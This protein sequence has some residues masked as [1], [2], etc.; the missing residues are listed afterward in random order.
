[1]GR[2]IAAALAVAV[3]ASLET[4]DPRTRRRCREVFGTW[5]AWRGDRAASARVRSV[6]EVVSGRAEHA[7]LLAPY[8]RLVRT[9]AGVAPPLWIE[10]PK[11]GSLSMKT[12]MASAFDR[13]EASV[14]AVRANASAAGA[15]FVVVRD[16]WARLKSAF[17]T[18]VDRLESRRGVALVNATAPG[19]LVCALCD[20]VDVLTHAR[21]IAHT[22]RTRLFDEGG[23]TH[24]AFSQ[25]WFLNAWDRPIDNVLR[26]EAYAADVE[27]LRARLPP[28]ALP[29]GAM[30]AADVGRNQNLGGFDRRP[31]DETGALPA[32]CADRVWAHLHQDYEC[33][34]YDVPDALRAAR[35][36]AE[37]DPWRATFSSARRRRVEATDRAKSK[38]TAP[39]PAP[40]GGLA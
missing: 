23:V 1:M 4:V 16:P 7:P 17:G 9:A 6:E 28:D 37:R 12:Y 22:N 38:G 5:D 3:A 11:A 27:A 2:A 13:R 26:L 24:H 25:M 19:D 35:D 34:A 21:D 14:A 8:G 10:V 15:T 30:A 39:A 32:T 18:I 40:P 20:L 36:R 29:P 33:L 31:L